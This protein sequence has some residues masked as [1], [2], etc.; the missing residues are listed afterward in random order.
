MNLETVKGWCV[1]CGKE[2]IF[3]VID[4]KPG[5]PPTGLESSDQW[6]CQKCGHTFWT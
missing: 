2:T 6:E 3:A 5:H 4:L 1:M